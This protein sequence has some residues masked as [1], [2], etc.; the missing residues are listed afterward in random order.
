[1]KEKRKLLWLTHHPNQTTRL[2][3][4]SRYYFRNFMGET[5]LL[6]ARLL[7]KNLFIYKYTTV[8][9]MKKKKF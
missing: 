8:Y 6:L 9:K 7:Y 3:R 2:K 5:K 4:H 1:M